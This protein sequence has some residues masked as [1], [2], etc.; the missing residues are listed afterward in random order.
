MPD[1]IPA[2]GGRQFWCPECRAALDHDLRAQ[3]SPLCYDCVKVR[4]SRK[5]LAAQNGAI[6]KAAETVIDLVSSSR[7][8]NGPNDSLV[9]KFFNVFDPE[10]IGQQAADICKNAMR[11]AA[12]PNADLK[13]MREGRNWFSK[14]EALSDRRQKM[15][16]ERR[17]AFDGM[18]PEDLK[19]LMRPLCVELLK[20][21][22]DFLCDIME[23]A[24]PDYV[25]EAV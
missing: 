22:P 20:N 24:K 1:F 3:G 2:N 23:E 11:N 12:G 6:I 16:E 4:S 25:L 15:L 8:D 21:D 5:A 10:Q 17:K 14:I 9:E 19:A 7:S 18:T 13:T